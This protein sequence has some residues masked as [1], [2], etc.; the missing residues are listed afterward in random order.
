LDDALAVTAT[1]PAA[2]RWL[3]EVSGQDRTDIGAL[4]SSIY[5]VAARLH[6]IEQR[7][8]L[9]PELMPRARLR[10][11]SGRWLIAHASRLAD[12]S[13]AG[14]VAV[15]LEPGEPAQI[16]PLYLRKHGAGSPESRVREGRCPQSPRIGRAGVDAAVLAPR[17]E[18]RSSRRGRL[19]PGECA[20]MM[21]PSH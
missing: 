2:D 19:V 8:E 16:A 14:A 20:P 10:T 12:A 6:A 4:P 1:T 13:H 7:G 11:R 5:A 17:R 3:A 15:I 18:R 9:A 21:P